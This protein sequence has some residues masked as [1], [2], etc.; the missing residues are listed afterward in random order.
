M[1]GDLPVPARYWEYSADEWNVAVSPNKLETLR[2][3][4]ESVKRE[5]VS[6]R[7]ALE[8]DVRSCKDMVEQVEVGKLRLRDLREEEACVMSSSSAKKAS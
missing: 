4:L 7:A 1:N 3:Q 6:L 2:Q 8:E 5:T